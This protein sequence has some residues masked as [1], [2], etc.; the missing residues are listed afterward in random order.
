MT[1]K[2]HKTIALVGKP[3]SG[4]TAL[5]NALTG[6]RQKVANYPGVTVERKEGLLQLPDGEMVTLLDLPGSYSLKS[7]SQ[8]ERIAR[9]VL[10]GN[11]TGVDKPDMVVCI[12]DATNL[13]LSL[14]LVLEVIALGLPVTLVLNKMDVAK[15]LGYE[16]SIERLSQQLGGITVLPMVA[17]KVRS[18][19]PLKETI[20]DQL[21]HLPSATKEMAP[22][23]ESIDLQQVLKAA[24]V[25][26]GQRDRVTATLDKLLLHPIFGTLAFLVIVF[27]TFQSVFSLAAMPMDMIDGFIGWLMET[28]GAHMPDSSLKDLITEGIIAGV[29]SVIIFLPQVLILFFFILLL[30]DTGY[31]ARAAFLLDRIMGRVGLH[32]KAFI[33]LLS[34]FACA[35]P[36]IMATRTIESP[37]DRLVTI[38][39]AP[40]MT[41]SARL[42][43]YALII[44]A[45]IPNDPV[46][47]GFGLQ[48]IVLFGLY[49][50]GIISAMIIAFVLRRFFFKGG[51][52][53][54][55]L[56][57]PD[58]S[59]PHARNLLLGLWERARIFVLRA[60]RIILPLM[61]LV[62]FLSSY[63]AAPEDAEGSSILYSFAGI[64]GTF[65]APIFAPLGF[66]WQMVVALIPGMAAREVAVGVLGT[67]YAVSAEENI[68]SLASL[69]A[70]EWSLPTALAFLTWYIF[71]PQCLPT[72]GIVKRETNSWKWPVVMFCYLM[73]VAY[74]ASMGVYHLSSGL[75]GHA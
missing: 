51:R 59:L 60:G 12:A 46:F 65:I 38:L 2:Q 71:A 15:R 21:Q 53:P 58:Y 19:Q 32:G 57:M 10:L 69:L 25:R 34:S 6:A 35:I 28:I 26:H 22:Q 13:R 31:M 63:P 3:N 66:N 54:L 52:A 55:L 45:F 16:I 1:P 70:S 43:V 75:L 5:F 24:M 67:V 33:P 27:L 23:G 18:T 64:I 20:A 44:S 7:E 17:T 40:L 50:S 37:R 73:G 41:C 9:D 8:D 42:P 74:L 4:K 47:W 30:E 72:L 48:G 29:G 14:P 61:I 68:D 56:E 11:I 39:I 36:G 49:I 62:W